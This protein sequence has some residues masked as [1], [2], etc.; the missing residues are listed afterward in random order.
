MLQLLFNSNE[1]LIQEALALS[2]ISVAHDNNH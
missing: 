1:V 2:R